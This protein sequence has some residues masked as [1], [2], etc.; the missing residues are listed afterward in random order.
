MTKRANLC[1]NQ[2]KI[3]THLIKD[4]FMFLV[5]FTAKLWPSMA[6]LD[7]VRCLDR[8]LV[9]SILLWEQRRRSHICV[10]TSL[11]PLIP[12][13]IMVQFILLHR[14]TLFSFHLCLIFLCWFVLC[15][16]RFWKLIKCYGYYVV[17]FASFH[18]SS[19]F[20]HILKQIKM[21]LKDT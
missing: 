4:V 20:H 5:Q 14:P 12:I 10:F 8:L 1:L 17:I 2:R 16:W 6:D 18:K 21:D 11:V 19:S 7:V 15:V 3:L 9:S 13:K